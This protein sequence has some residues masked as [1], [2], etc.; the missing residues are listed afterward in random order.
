MSQNTPCGQS[1]THLLS[2]P[3]VGDFRLGFED[4]EVQRA[5]GEGTI[6]VLSNKV[7]STIEP[8]YWTFQV[9]LFTIPVATYRALIDQAYRSINNFLATGRGDVTVNFSGMTN[10]C[11]IVKV[12]PTKS[13]FDYDGTEYIDQIQITLI[14]P[15]NTLF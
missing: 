1:H 5:S 10:K 14:N 11:Y 7:L 13:F 6:K 12:P 9:T 8:G 15:T 2:I 3:N 4:Y